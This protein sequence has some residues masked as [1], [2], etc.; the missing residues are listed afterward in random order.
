MS[1][2]RWLSKREAAA[3]VGCSEETLANA[4]RRGDLR[5][6]GTPRL[7]RIREDWLD[8]WLATP[9]TKKGGSL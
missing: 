8:E 3:I 1:E 4:I 2:H 6:G 5:A 7:V 9:R